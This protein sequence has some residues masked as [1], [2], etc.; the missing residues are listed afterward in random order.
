MVRRGFYGLN[1]RKG[2]A[3]KTLRD[4]F[5]VFFLKKLEIMRKNAIFRFVFIFIGNT[6]MKRQLMGAG[7]L[8]LGLLLWG[9]GTGSQ[10]QS[11]AV[12]VQT[13]ALS[14]QNIEIWTLTGMQ[15]STSDTLA[16][17]EE[18][19]VLNDTGHLH[20]EVPTTMDIDALEFSELKQ[21]LSDS[22]TSG[23]FYFGF[24][25]CPWCRNLLP[26]LFAAMQENGLSKLYYYNP[27][28]IRDKKVLNESG[29]VVT[30]VE[31]GPEYQYLLER[32]DEVLPEYEGLN[33][34]KIK[35][36]Y[37]PFVVVLKDGKIVGHHLSTLD[38]QT[39]P[40]IP[41][42]EELKHKLRKVLT[43]QFSSLIQYGCDPTAAE[44]VNC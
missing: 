30:E 35:R 8:G 19:E 36:L 25:T 24:P 7:I 14:G 4:D 34:P 31:T 10:E 41:L 28:A 29:V 3:L 42:T 39:D 26:E 16:F 32:L 27:K 11:V 13:G 12:D 5:K 21:L 43:E 33:D 40:A 23:I 20:I 17:K 38:E 18:Y 37:V 44:H 9:C 6:M 2:L 22:K 15:T 1:F